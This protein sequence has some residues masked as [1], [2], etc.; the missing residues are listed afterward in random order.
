RR[1]LYELTSREI[2][3]IA[4]EF[5]EEIRKAEAAT[6]G[7]IY[8]RYSSRFQHSISDQVRTLY[9]AA[10]RQGIRV[11]REYVCF[12]MAV[13]GCKAQRPGLSGLRTVLASK[14]VGVLLVFTTNRL[15]R[16][17]YKALQFIEEEVVERGIR[18]LFVKSGVD[19]ADEKRWRTLLQIHAMTDE[20][21][22]GMYADNV[23]AAHEEL[24]DHHLLFGKIT[25]GYL[26]QPI[27][28]QFTKR[29]RPRCRLLVDPESAKWVQNAFNWFV[30]DRLSIGEIV[31]RLNADSSVP[32]GPKCTSG[33][34][35][36]Q[37]VR[38]ML[39]NPRYRGWWF[40]GATQ[41]VWQT[42]KDYSRQIARSE[43]L[44]STQFEELRIVSDKL[45]YGAEKRLAEQDHTAVGRKPR[46]GNQASRP[47][48][49]NGLFRCAVHDRPLYVG[50]SHGQYLF[51]KSCRAMRP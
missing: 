45:W 23:R 13:R 24:F 10:L 28:G 12:D 4:A 8:A 5:D 2:D 33:H 25:F 47:K 20:F 46:D 29:N 15:F 7:A 26:A 18:C 1:Q 30:N 40:Y 11:P 36:H 39:S 37:A 35:T 6:V 32:L 9:E 22:V 48:L 44:R 42:K 50:G 34:W 16:K 49:L 3:L 19:S 17:T 14:G 21:V 43:P 27:P 38:G 31:R 51:C 41:N